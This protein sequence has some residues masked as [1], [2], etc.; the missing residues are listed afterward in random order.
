MKALDAAFLFFACTVI[1]FPTLALSDDQYQPSSVP[2][3]SDPYKNGIIFAPNPSLPG[4]KTQLY[5]KCSGGDE[6]TY[7]FRFEAKD[8]GAGHKHSNA[9][10]PVGTLNPPSFRLKC[11]DQWRPTGEYTAPDTSGFVQI[12]N[13]ANG[14]PTTPPT[15]DFIVSVPGLIRLPKSKY[16]DE[17]H[18]SAMDNVLVMAPPHDHPD[19]HW[20]KA[21]LNA[22]LLKIAKKYYE[23]RNKKLVVNDM[24]LAMGGIL[25]FN[26]TW[27]APHQTHKDGR[28]VDIQMIGAMD[29][30]DRTAFKSIAESVFGKRHVCIDGGTHWHLVIETTCTDTSLEELG[31]S[32]KDLKPNMKPL[33]ESRQ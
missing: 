3:G 33:I 31:Y 32:E 20:G 19:N 9:G 15:T 13:Y 28:H 11:D 5:T 27:K 16:I 8:N 6:A 14:K 24:S 22:K 18:Y 30:D 26:N 12:F 23:A 2:I 4:A 10:R 21:D 7:T 25:D 1:C 29:P 17:V